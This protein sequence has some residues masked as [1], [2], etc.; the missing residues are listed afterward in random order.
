MQRRKTYPA[1]IRYRNYASDYLG[2]RFLRHISRVLS[3]VDL[4]DEQ[5]LG[6][7]GCRSIEVHSGPVSIQISELA[8]KPQLQLTNRV[9]KMALRR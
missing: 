8:G 7:D 5:T 2:S 6:R 3:K 1:C 4:K 9:T